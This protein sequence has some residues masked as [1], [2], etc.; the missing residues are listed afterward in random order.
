ML[1]I[2][3]VGWLNGHPIQ[4]KSDHTRETVLSC[5]V[6]ARLAF[7]FLQ[8]GVEWAFAES[9]VIRPVLCKIW[10]IGSTE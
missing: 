5:I 9:Q 10:V 2:G 1:R 4:K 6:R 7:G 3:T 8:S